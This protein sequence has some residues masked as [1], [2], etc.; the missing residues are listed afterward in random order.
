[1]EDYVLNFLKAEWKVSDT[2]STHW[3]SDLNSYEYQEIAH[4]YLQDNLFG[5]VDIAFTS[6]EGYRRFYI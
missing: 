2:D 5:V 4:I 6:N 1:M 3:A